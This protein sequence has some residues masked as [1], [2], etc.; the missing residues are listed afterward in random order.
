MTGSFRTG[1][2]I[3]VAAVAF[4]VGGLTAQRPPAWTACKTDSLS[5]YNCASYYS[6]TVTLN[7]TLK[8]AG[9]NEFTVVTATVTAGKVLCQ[10]KTNE[11][12]EFTAPGM[13][14][15]EHDNNA[16]AGG[17]EIKIWCPE[18]PGQRVTRD[19]YPMI[20]V[21]KQES[22]DYTR[23]DGEESY[24]HPDTD[25]VNGVSGNVTTSWHLERK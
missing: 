12:A 9:V 19:D 21:M 18:E 7:S 5:T 8:A 25:G 4:G 20:E 24:E 16:N 2:L 6:G 11:I 22:R 3:A 15:V 13:I 14:M 17:Y 23:L 10:L 1:L